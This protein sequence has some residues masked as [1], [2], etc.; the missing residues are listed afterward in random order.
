MRE[1]AVTQLPLSPIEHWLG[2]VALTKLVADLCVGDDHFAALLKL[3][4]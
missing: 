3:C 1:P 4:D 2:H